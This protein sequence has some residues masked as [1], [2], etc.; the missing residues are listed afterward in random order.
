MPT[1]TSAHDLITAIPF[2]IGFHP[3]ESIVLISIKDEA[4]GLAMRIDL[5]QHLGS[6]EIDLLAH[7]FLREEADAALLVAYMPD[8]RDDGD[9]L[10][11][12]LGAGLI[13]NGIDI[14]ESL[15]VRSGRYRSI[16]C[17]DESC[18]S[19]QG[20]SLPDIESTEIAAE[21]VVAGIPMPYASIEELKETLAADPSSLDLEWS[22]LVGQF[23][24]AED[25]E[26]LQE[27]R[28][29]GIE[30]M[31]L[32]FDDF[33]MGR[34]ASEALLV[35]RMIGRMSDVQVRDYAL[36]VH[37]ED[38]FDIY[39]TMWRE[40]LR[41]APRGYVAPIA[42]IVAAMSYESGDGALAQKALDRALVD[43]ERY[44]LA[45][46]LR[47]VFNAGWPPESFAQMRRELHPKVI[48]AIFEERL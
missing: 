2:L 33:R 8:C 48:D 16:I 15:V 1:L 11:I 14:Q 32:L 5:P 37:S 46:L 26:S 40:L 4:I 31:D 38:T 47:R 36:G 39:F 17:R 35:A 30:T 25:S 3:T 23:F 29:D 13:R 20:K 28:R 9:S 41:L 45:G 44:P 24:I 19:P 27:L 42:C 10:L 43:D 22:D 12:S 34:G 18:C 7:H 6:D 21:H